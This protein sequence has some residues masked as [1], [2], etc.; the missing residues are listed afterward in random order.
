MK[1]LC[2]YFLTLLLFSDVYIVVAMVSRWWGRGWK[3]RC[4]GFTHTWLWCLQRPAHQV[5]VLAYWAIVLTEVCTPLV[6]HTCSLDGGISH[7]YLRHTHLCLWYTPE[8]IMVSSRCCTSVCDTRTSFKLCFPK[9]APPCF[10]YAHTCSA[11]RNDLWCQGLLTAELSDLNSKA[12][13]SMLVY[14]RYRK[15]EH[16]TI[17]LQGMG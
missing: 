8:A 3:E 2:F 7:I 14:M 1:N 13:R 15:F 6:P 17:N 9:A 5:V 11:T 4:G 16:I 12:A 10:G